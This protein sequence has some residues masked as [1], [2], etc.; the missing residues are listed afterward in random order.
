MYH[1]FFA[2]AETYT[3]SVNSEILSHRSLS[4]GA[5]YRNLVFFEKNFADQIARQRVEI[6]DSKFQRSR[7]LYMSLHLQKMNDTSLSVS[8]LLKDLRISKFF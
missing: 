3:M 1:S 4:V 7:T 5:I 6:Y 8:E 2:N